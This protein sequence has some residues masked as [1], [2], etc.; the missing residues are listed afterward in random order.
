MNM[1]LDIEKKLAVIIDN[2]LNSRLLRI[3]GN[4]SA[5][6]SSV[7]TML[8]NRYQSKAYYRFINND[9]VKSSD[10]VSLFGSYSSHFM[11]DSRVVLA[12]QD[13]S[14]LD[15][16]GNRSAAEL[17]CME[18]VHRKGLYLH[19]QLLVDGRG[20]AQGILSQ[21]FISRSVESL[22]KAAARKYDK[23]EDKESY[24]WVET[25]NI[26]QDK[27]GDQTEKL[28]IVFVIEKEILVNYYWLVNTNI[29]TI[30]F[31]VKTIVNRQTKS[32]I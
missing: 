22:G 1:F 2:R 23:F 7:C 19:T 26:L 8:G 17:G 29:F 30:L 6:E 24:R 3:V 11:S 12:L 25:F 28:F 32:I 15:Y 4:F 5:G 27:F 14:E 9:K 18:Y 16:T 31:A 20:L 10:L 13:T 21:S